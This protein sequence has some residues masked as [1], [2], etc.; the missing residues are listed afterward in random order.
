MPRR[1]LSLLSLFRA[2]LVVVCADTCE[3]EQSEEERQHE[4]PPHVD[5]HQ[6]TCPGG[7]ACVAEIHDLTHFWRGGHQGRDEAKGHKDGCRHL[8]HMDLRTN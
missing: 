2:S 1:Y 3:R 7:V 4:R 5:I 6:R 8:F